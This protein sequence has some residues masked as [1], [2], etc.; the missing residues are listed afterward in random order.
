MQE[1]TAPKPYYHFASLCR[2]GAIVILIVQLM[3]F[4]SGI[5]QWVGAM[6]MAQTASRSVGGVLT[7]SNPPNPLASPW[8]A[9]MLI[10]KLTLWLVVAHVLY[11]RSEKIG[12]AIEGKKHRRAKS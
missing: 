9:V 2:A 6:G 5:L 10:A 8:I 7:V 12:A 1:H 4:A 3:A 11:W